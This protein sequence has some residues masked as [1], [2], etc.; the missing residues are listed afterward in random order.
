MMAGASPYGADLD[1]ASQSKDHIIGTNV[2]AF[3]SRGPTTRFHRLSEAIVCVSAGFGP[4]GV[5][6]ISQ[7]FHSLWQV[8]PTG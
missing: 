5:N 3:T 2:K 1:L 4:G 7:G 8:M 6:Q